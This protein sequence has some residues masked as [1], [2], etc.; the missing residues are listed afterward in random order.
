M[1]SDRQVKCP[2]ACVQHTDLLNNNGPE[3]EKQQQHNNVCS[4]WVA[5]K[6]CKKSILPRNKCSALCD[7]WLDRDTQMCSSMGVCCG[8]ERGCFVSHSYNWS[9]CTFNSYYPD[10]MFSFF[11]FLCPMNANVHPL[12]GLPPLPRRLILRLQRWPLSVYGWLNC[13]CV[14]DLQKLSPQSFIQMVIYD[15][16]LIRE[17][18]WLCTCPSLSIA[19]R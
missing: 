4:G 7:G 10:G 1:H 14:A 6:H 9:C 19:S 3:K 13:T 17:N 15:R 16:L 2:I 18:W 11:P 12:C 8:A 5:K